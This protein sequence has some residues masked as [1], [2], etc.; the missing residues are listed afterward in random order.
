MRLF[1]LKKKKHVKVAPQAELCR[2]CHL[3][4]E[5]YS[6]KEILREVRPSVFLLCYNDFRCLLCL[7]MTATLMPFLTPS[8]TVQCLTADSDSVF[9]LKNTLTLLSAVCELTG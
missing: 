5:K 9:E 4:S 1:I 8:T 2:K 3:Y 6:T 7:Q